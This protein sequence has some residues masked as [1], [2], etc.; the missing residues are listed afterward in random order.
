[1]NKKQVLS[2]VC[3]IHPNRI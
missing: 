3:R 2:I 1:M